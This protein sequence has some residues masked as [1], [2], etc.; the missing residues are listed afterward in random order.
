MLGTYPDARVLSWTLP[1]RRG[2][3]RR[4]A[5]RGNARQALVHGIRGAAKT[6]GMSAALLAASGVVG[7]ARAPV[8]LSE[9]SQ[10][11]AVQ[12]AA[13]AQAAPHAAL[14]ATAS[15]TR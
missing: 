6:A 7:A 8:V 4:L 5:L 15:T 13:P 10:P 2:R 12:V 11:T 14:V 3:V 9:P 1:V